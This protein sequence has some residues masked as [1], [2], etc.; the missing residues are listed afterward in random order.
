MDIVLVFSSYIVDLVVGDPRWPLHPVRLMG[1]LIAFFDRFLKR[2][3]HWLIERLKGIL[4]VLFV[5]VVSF[6]C[7][8]LLI[9]LAR[10]LHP[11]AG[12]IMWVFLAYTT[13][14]T[15]DLLHHARSVQKAII[16]GDIEEA[17]LRL[18]LIVGR[19]TKSLFKKEIVKATIE[20]IAENT[21]DGIVAPL[22]YLFLG[23]PAVAMCYKAINTIDSMIGHRNEKY[24]NF[25]WFGA[26][27]DDVANFIPARISG[28]L[29][30]IGSFLLGSGIK[31]PFRMMMRDRKKHSSPN[32][33]VSEAAM[34]GALSIQLGGVY[35]YQGIRIER[36][37]I[38]DP[39]KVISQTMIT[40]ALFI[41]IMTSILMVIIGAVVKCTI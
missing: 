14:S 35:A 26:K 37:T 41:S 17:R 23:G 19:D 13:L 9:E 27:L 10:R 22:F 2:K 3:S 6:L 16:K 15:R 18:S 29:I 33:A 7:T 5:I 32:S 24:A 30:S 1:R 8:Y 38:G 4:M 34:A 11:L 31:K 40:K 12:V 36:P 25:G 21:N 28:L 39:E 20:S